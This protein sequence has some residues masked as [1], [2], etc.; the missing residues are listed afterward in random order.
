MPNIYVPLIV[1]RVSSVPWKQ[2]KDTPFKLPSRE[3][4]LVIVASFTICLIIIAYFVL[5][6]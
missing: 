3:E 2:Y 5:T 6:S 4:I 1:R